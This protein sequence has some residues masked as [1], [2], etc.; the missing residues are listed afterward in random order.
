M[1]KERER[2]HELTNGAIDTVQQQH[3]GSDTEDLEADQREIQKQNQ[4]LIAQNQQLQEEVASVR[5][6]YE[7]LKHNAEQRSVESELEHWLDSDKAKTL[8]QERDELQ[9]ELLNVKSQLET[10]TVQCKTLEAEKRAAETVMRELEEER[11]ALLKKHQEKAETVEEVTVRELLGQKKRQEIELAELKS[12]VEMFE[13]KK[14]M[15]SLALPDDSTRAKQDLISELVE[16]RRKV[17]VVTDENSKLRAELSHFE[18]VVELPKQS[19]KPKNKLLKVA[20]KGMH[21]IDGC[22]LVI[23][24]RIRAKPSPASSPQ[25]LQLIF[26]K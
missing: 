4:K 19:S 16:L 12:K 9:Q 13:T 3:G 26:I 5:K 11:D 8:A 18:H 15:E 22:S 25:T 7:E 2:T 23:L 21:V 6:Q 24:F 20:K 1:L 17:Q 10:Y 14:K